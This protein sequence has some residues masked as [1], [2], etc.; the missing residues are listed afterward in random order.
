MKL[1]CKY[2]TPGRKSTEWYKDGKPMRYCYGWLDVQTDDLVKTCQNC[3]HHVGKANDDYQAYLHSKE[4]TSYK[5]RV[6]K[7]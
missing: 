4:S 1:D 2:G 7:Q 6:E 5:E 3:P